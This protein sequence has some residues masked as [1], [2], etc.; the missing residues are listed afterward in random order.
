MKR[1]ISSVAFAVLVSLSCVNAMAGTWLNNNRAGGINNGYFTSS[2]PT[3]GALNGSLSVTDFLFGNGS[4]A[5]S[6][7]TTNG[8]IF[9]AGSDNF[10]VFGSVLND[11]Y[12]FSSTAFGSFSGNV[13]E[14]QF[15]GNL[16]NATG[17][18]TRTL[19]F[20]GVFTPGNNS[21]YEGDTT[22]LSN[23]SL[24]I[25]FSRNN[26]GSVS[27]SWS[28]DTTGAASVPEPTSIAIFGLGAVGFAVRRFRRK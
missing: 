14:E 4:G 12:T 5:F 9:F 28:L 22:P 20:I 21:F 1:L 27:T 16:G 2:T 3:S 13:T 10:D 25:T 8:T 23:T 26:G 6:G 7:A 18:A 17:T 24:T 15:S 11:S 19:A